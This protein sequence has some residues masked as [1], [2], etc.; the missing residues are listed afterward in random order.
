MSFNQCKLYRGACRVARSMARASAA[1]MLSSSL[2]QAQGSGSSLY[3]QFLDPP[4]NARPIIAMVVVLVQPL[5]KPDLKKELDTMR[6]AGIGGVEIQP[7]YPLMLDDESR[8]LKNCL[9]CL[10]NSWTRYN[11][12][13]TPRKRWACAS[14]SL[15][16]AAGPTVDLR[17]NSH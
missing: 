5:P 8:A 4:S 14:I 11:L 10:Q 3:R 15:W 12:P 1:L 2:L 7:V 13:T 17:P 9:T 6:N 16:A